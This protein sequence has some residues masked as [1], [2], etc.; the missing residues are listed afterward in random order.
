TDLSQYETGYLIVEGM[1][2]PFSVMMILIYFALF[3]TLAFT[4]FSKRDIAS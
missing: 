4:V 2:M 1:T 3:V